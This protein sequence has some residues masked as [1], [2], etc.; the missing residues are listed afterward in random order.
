MDSNEELNPA[1][2]ARE[3]FDTV[4]DKSILITK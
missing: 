2:D 4:N 3:N 1:I